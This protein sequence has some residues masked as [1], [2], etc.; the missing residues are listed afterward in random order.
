VRVTLKALKPNG[1]RGPL[2]TLGNH[3]KAKRLSLGMYQKDVAKQL[4]VDHWTLLNWEKN[5]TA[6]LVTVYPAIV[7]FLGYD[8]APTPVTIAER[9]KARRRQL[10]GRSRRPPTDWM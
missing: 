4:G 6:P 5:R 9:L 7:A 2:D 1:F 8:P 10:G 3:L